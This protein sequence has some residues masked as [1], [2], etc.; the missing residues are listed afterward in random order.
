[1]KDFVPNHMEP[2]V[3]ILHC[4]S[5]LDE[6]VD[7]MVLATLPCFKTFGVVCDQ[8]VVIA[9]HDFA[10]DIMHAALRWSPTWLTTPPLSC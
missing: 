4:H 8:L 6:V 10:F 9:K 5:T 1:M 3:D 2:V 7:D